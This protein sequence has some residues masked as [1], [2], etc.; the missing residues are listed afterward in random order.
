MRP[1][2]IPVTLLLGVVSEPRPSETL[3]AAGCGGLFS[4]GCSRRDAQPFG[5]E[6]VVLIDA[7]SFQKA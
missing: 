5:T 4:A 6:T 3:Q 7:R 2:R 1:V